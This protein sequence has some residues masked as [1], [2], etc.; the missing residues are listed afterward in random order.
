MPAPKHPIDR[1]V[2]PALM[3]VFLALAAV[4][5]RWPDGDTGSFGMQLA[6]GL[7]LAVFAVYWLGW[8]LR[9]HEL[10][11][12]ARRT[13]AERRTTTSSGPTDPGPQPS[14]AEPGWQQP[15]GAEPA[16]RQPSRAEPGWQQP[17]G[18]EPTTTWTS[19]QMPLPAQRPE[20]APARGERPPW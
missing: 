15:T 8:L 11:R 5:S 10:W 3:L 2:L 18:A 1:P 9:G 4:L 7:F 19:Q 16:W 12:D 14:R 13:D 17:T 20:R 6:L